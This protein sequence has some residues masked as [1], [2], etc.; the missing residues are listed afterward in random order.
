MVSGIHGHL[1][2]V[3]SGVSDVTGQSKKLKFRELLPFLT[4]RA[5]PLE[6]K[7]RV[8]ASCVRSSMT[9][10]YYWFIS[11][12]SDRVG[13][14]LHNILSPF[15]PVM[16]ISVDLKV[17]HVH[18]YTLQPCPSWSSNRSSALNS[19]YFFTQSSWGT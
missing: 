18:F 14:P 19:I 10:I 4:S 17:C 5:L 6:M 8:N 2:L 9:Y 11:P 3:V 15:I 12:F 16:D 13:L 7:G 1:S